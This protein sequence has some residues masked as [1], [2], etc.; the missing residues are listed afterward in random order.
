MV[1]DNKIQCIHDIIAFF[2]YVIIFTS[3]SYYFLFLVAF[4]T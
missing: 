3:F 4:D 1:P 2:C